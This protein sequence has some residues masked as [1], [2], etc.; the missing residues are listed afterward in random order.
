MKSRAAQIVL[1][2][3][4]AMAGFPAQTTAAQPEVESNLVTA[5]L[6]SGFRLFDKQM[7]IYMYTQ[8]FK[9]TNSNTDKYAS[10]CKLHYSLLRSDGSVATIGNK[11]TPT[12]PPKGFAYSALWIAQDSQIGPAGQW[13]IVRLDKLDCSPTN[14]SYLLYSMG[15]PLTYK[16]GNETINGNW[17]YSEI[18]I[19]NDGNEVVSAVGNVA[20][21]SQNYSVI[22]ASA[23]SGQDGC[24]AISLLPG[25]EITCKINRE[26]GTPFQSYLINWIRSG[27]DVNQIVFKALPKQT[28]VCVKGKLSK[29][30]T[31]IKPKCPAG[32]KRK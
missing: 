4:F 3:F 30:V 13:S 16:L 11:L 25:Q 29:K 19:K 21:V 20:L 5:K 18:T 14:N 9:L 26:L 7:G 31:A 24:Y 22:G 27:Y 10:G 32:Y 2:I 28:I 6:E 12:I 8:A 15:A 23:I 1:I 17:V